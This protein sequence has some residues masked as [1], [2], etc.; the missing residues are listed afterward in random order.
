M[1]V[2]CAGL[3]LHCGDDGAGSGGAGGAGGGGTSAQTSTTSTSS[4]TAM[5]TGAGAGDPCPAG[6]TCVESFPF[7][8]ERDTST[9]GTT[10]IA[11]YDC[12]PNTNEGGPEIL[13]RV[14]VQAPGYLS[15][16]V[17]DAAGDDLDVHILSDL[18]P[19]APSGVFCM[20][21]GDVQAGADVNPGYLWVVADTWVNGSGTAL[22]G[23]YQLDIGFTPRS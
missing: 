13:Y 19:A 21:R 22:S 3:T 20:S 1:L 15:V 17:Y 2:C 12:A 7:H 4:T 14:A 18:D 11:S 8:D 6:V 9:E 16:A 10:A 23:P 5:T